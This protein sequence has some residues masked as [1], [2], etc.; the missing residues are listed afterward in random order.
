[1]YGAWVYLHKLLKIGIELEDLPVPKWIAHSIL[2]LGFGLLALRLLELGGRIL[3]GTSS[4]FEHAD[5]AKE[6]LRDVEKEQ[7][8]SDV[9]IPR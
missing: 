9:E 8:A 4:G 5:E 3:K 7:V 6:A 2:L 1:M